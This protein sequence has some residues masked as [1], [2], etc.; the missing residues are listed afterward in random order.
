MKKK[1]FRFSSLESEEILHVIRDENGLKE[2]IYDFLKLSLAKDDLTLP[3]DDIKKYAQ[4]QVN[5]IKEKISSKGI[6]DSLQKILVCKT[7]GE[8]EKVTANL[9]ISHE[10]F[11]SFIYNC[12]VAN[13]A[14]EMKSFQYIPD[15]LQTNPEEKKSFF[16]SSVGNLEGQALK[17]FK[18][19]SNQFKFRKNVV[20]HLFVGET[21]WHCFYFSY[22]DLFGIKKSGKNHWEYGDHVHYTS[23]LFGIHVTKERAW[24]ELDNKK[25]NLPNL[26]IKYFKN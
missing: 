5:K 16:Q 20:A 19:I 4:D 7:K 26:H 24:T 10:D 17:F 21:D 6:P 14:H 23:S 15:H 11:A 2:A 8:L 3:D 22:D 12:A 1:S 18:K 9:T 13:L 25:Y